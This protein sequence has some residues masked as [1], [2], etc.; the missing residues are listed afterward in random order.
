MIGTIFNVVGIL[1]GGLLGLTTK[2]TLPPAAEAQLKIILA[3]L[4]VFFGLRLTWLSLSGPM[5][6]LLKQGVII[7]FSL[8]LGKLTGKL[9][10]LQKFSNRLG[11]YAHQRIIAAQSSPAHPASDGFTP[12]AVLFCAAPLGIIGAIQDGLSQRGFFY[13]LLI[14]AVIDGL[15][16]L[17]LVRVLGWGVLLS[18]IPVL[19]LQGTITLA[20]SHLLG[21]F[22][23]ARGLLDSIN[24]VGGLLLFSIALVMLG[25]K[26][27]ELTDYLPSLIF[28]PML[29]WLWR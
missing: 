6:L 21:P 18:A 27:I 2:K 19:T 10:R 15:A 1:I 26:R 5:L 25:L 17:G 7:I 23:A 20:C 8:I 16:S 24:A 28:G 14:K 22:L 4:T 13:P 9:L 29:T 3:A 11:Q 12:C